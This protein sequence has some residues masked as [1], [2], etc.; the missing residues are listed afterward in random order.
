MI[1]SP[2]PT[3]PRPRYIWPWYIAAAMVLGVVIAVFAIRAEANR[4]KQQKQYQ[5]PP[6]ER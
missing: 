1:D 2:P 3:E 6:G 5:L 4:V